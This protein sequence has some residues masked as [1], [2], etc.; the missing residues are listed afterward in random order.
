MTDDV[1]LSE[2]RDGVLTLTLNRPRQRNALDSSLM[3]ALLA[4]L[5][6]AAED[7]RVRCVI[8]RGSGPD[9]CTGGDIGAAKEAVV[10]GHEPSAEE[11]AAAV[12]RLARRGPVSDEVK[13]GWLERNMQSARLL[14]QMGKPTIAILQGN[15]IGA[16][17]GLA[18]ACD[19]RVATEDA[20]LQTGFIRFGYAGDY[21]ASYFMTRLVGTARAR[22]LF[23]LNERIDARRMAELGLVTR[24]VPTV[25]EATAV[26]GEMA[27]R[28]AA[29]PPLTL[30]YIKK[31][32]N[33][34]ADQP[35]ERAFEVEA[36]NQQ[37]AG[38]TE[39]SREAIR[40]LVEKRTPLFQG[41]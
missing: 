32:L 13:L 31:N 24:L 19:F 6:D 40:A 25:D 5:T 28:L 8:L 11:L 15:I 37:R 38:A 21:G 20:R 1:L 41:K 29:A 36:L 18:G 10:G 9:F 34:A 23:L 26:A 17:V 12:E 39:D 33:T 3:R 7:A 30:R 22:E 35:L 14:H 2:R 27:Q 16:G 4:A